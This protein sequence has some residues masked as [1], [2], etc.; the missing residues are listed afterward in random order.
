VKISQNVKNRIKMK[1]LLLPLL[2][3]LISCSQQK[4]VSSNLDEIF[5]INLTDFSLEDIKNKGFKLIPDDVLIYEL[6][7]DN[8]VTCLRFDEDKKKCSAASWKKE[9]V[10]G[11]KKEVLGYLRKF[12]F[13]IISPYYSDC[14]NEDTSYSF[15]AVRSEVDNNV[16]FFTVTKDNDKFYLTAI[17]HRPY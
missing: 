13:S 3:F 17:Y 2:L 10:S 11:N 16:F 12:G 4:E 15:T 14:L 6:K 1:K 5:N 7:K 8:F 9:L